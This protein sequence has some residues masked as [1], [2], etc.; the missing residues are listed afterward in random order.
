LPKFVL[1]L[2]SDLQTPDDAAVDF[3]DVKEGFKGLS[4]EAKIF[5]DST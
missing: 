4:F 5:F 3:E 1:F 2:Q